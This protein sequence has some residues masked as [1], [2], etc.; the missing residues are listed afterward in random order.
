MLNSKK[1]KYIL[2]L[3]LI[4]GL[5]ACEKTQIVESDVPVRE[6]IVVNSELNSA[7]VFDGVTFTKTLPVGVTY[8]IKAAELKDV[9]AY[10]KVNGIQVIP[11]HYVINGI[12][13][14]LYEIIIQAGNTYELFAERGGT[15]I[16]STTKVPFVPEINQANYIAGGFYIQASIKVHP[17]E[18]YGAIWVIGQGVDKAS[19]FPSLGIPDTSALSISVITNNIPDRYL[20]NLYA[21]LRNIQVYSYDKQ[22]LEYFNS[23]KINVPAGNG[24]MQ[25]GGTVGWNVYGNNVIGM[26]IGVGKG[27]IQN[28]N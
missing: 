20:G 24:F 1:M 13:K 9:K 19:S 5:N 3:P 22:Y 25:S 18:V 23:A 11:L 17:D 28:V 10:I 4:L 14:P 7:S 16:Y 2:L 21:G 15:T 8:N 27:E 26:F 12:Y 6:Y